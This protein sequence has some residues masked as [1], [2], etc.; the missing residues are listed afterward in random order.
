MAGMA[1]KA[2]AFCALAFGLVLV[3][4]VEAHSLITYTATPDSV[5]RAAEVRDPTVSRVIYRELTPGSS[6]TWIRFPGKKGQKIEFTLGVPRIARLSG[7][8]PSVALVGP[9]L[10]AADV[11]FAV[12]PG[13]GALVFASE[14]TSQA[15]PPVFHEEFTGTDSWVHVKTESVLPA[16]GEFY[17]VAFAPRPEEATGKAWLA[18][19]RK[20]RFTLREILGFCAIKRFVREFHELR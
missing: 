2:A 14:H 7:F 18:V 19:G 9:G 16:S 8:R 13:A 10:P 1:R 4:S 12:P 5:G 15:E 20:E 11:P 17:L 3:R 6:Q